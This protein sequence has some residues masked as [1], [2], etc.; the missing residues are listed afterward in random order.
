MFDTIS[1][2]LILWSLLFL[3]IFILI[4]ALVL[5]VIKIL[6]LKGNLDSFGIP[7]DSS[8]KP[9]KVQN[10]KAGNSIGNASKD[11]KEYHK[12]SKDD[13]PNSNSKDANKSEDLKENSKTFFKALLNNIKEDKVPDLG[14]QATFYLVL[15][16]FPFF[17]FLLS[18]LQYTPL[19]YAT[20]VTNIEGLLPE[21]AQELI[22]GTIE[23]VFS[24]SSGTLLSFSVIGALWS[25]LK[26]ANGLIKAVNT[27]YNVEETRNFFQVKGVALLITLGVP[28]IILLAFFFI[29]FGEVLG[30]YVFDFIGLSDNFIELWS[31]LRFPIPIITMILFFMLFYKFAPSLHLKFK[32]VF[33][34]ALFTV[35]F[36]LIASLGFS[37]YV[38]NFGNYSNVYGSLG[39]VIVVLLWLYLSSII[40]II[41]G[42]I[43]VVLSRLRKGQL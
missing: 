43:N 35:I 42:E 13:D 34:G 7:H 17:I 38:N 16:L 30:T 33:W 2:D 12:D 28:V 39:S 24:G 31:W 40:I 37:L 18:V 11:Q 10:K 29:V 36:W 1:L 32:N 6:A 15:A 3:G 8:T 26:G 4:I 23:E 27:A 14:A 20:I 21:Q 5:L 19:D 22:F 9:V 25:S 41:G